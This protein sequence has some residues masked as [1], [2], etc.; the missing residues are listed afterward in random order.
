MRA[1]VIIMA[2][3]INFSCILTGSDVLYKCGDGRPYT[4]LTVGV[5]SLLCLLYFCLE[6]RL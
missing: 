3:I 6:E 2:A 5:I 4:L 1:L